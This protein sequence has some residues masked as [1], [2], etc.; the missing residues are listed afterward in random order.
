VRLL[1]DADY[2]HPVPVPPPPRT[3][4]ALLARLP[5]ATRPV[6]GEPDLMHHKYAVR[7]EA[8]VWTGSLNW[9]DDSW[10]RQENVV[11][12]AQS[13]PLAHA[14]RLNFDELWK[15]QRV[16]GSGLVEPRPVEVGDVQVR[17]WFTPG[18][19]RDLA[20]R[21]AKRIGS[22]RRRVRIASPVLSSGPILGTLAEVCSE[23][24]ADVAGVIDDTQVDGVLDQWRLNG[25]STWKVPVLRRLLEAASWSGKP[26][27]EWSPDAVH[28]YMH[29]K[30]V[31]A[32][33]VSFVGSFNLSRSGELNAENVLELRD[34]TVA[35]R[36]AA[37]VDEVRALYPPVSLPPL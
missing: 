30:V 37:F 28:D 36:L 22:A 11:V 17:P 31:V 29:A 1:Y 2:A 18:R 23:G 35:D 8:A 14:F 32:D 26:S 5:L 9:T 27:T 10:T 19:G 15:R 13:E 7:D 20:H 3:E 12:V 33:D 21:I 16:E 4:P 6:P 24:R 34:A 25:N